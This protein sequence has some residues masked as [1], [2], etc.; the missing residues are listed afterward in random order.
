MA[1]SIDDCWEW[2]CKEYTFHFLWCCYAIAWGI[3]TYDESKTTDS[4]T[5]VAESAVTS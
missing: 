1:F 2:G 3:K 5:A 4:A